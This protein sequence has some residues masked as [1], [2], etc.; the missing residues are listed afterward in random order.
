[1]NPWLG[2]VPLSQVCTMF[3]TSKLCQAADWLF[4]LVAVDSPASPMAVL[5]EFQVAVV[6]AHGAVTRRASITTSFS[7]GS[8]PHDPSNQ[9]CSCAVVSWTP[10]GRSV[11]GNLISDRAF[12]AGVDPTANC[13]VPS[14]LVVGASERISTSSDCSQLIGWI[15]MVGS[16]TTG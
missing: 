1:M 12:I 6:S 4:A 11:R 7:P 10:E 9:V 15:L 2:W 8:G 14:K 5:I 13:Q 16:T 3:L